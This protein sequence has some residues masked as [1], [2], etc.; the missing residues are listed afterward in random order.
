MH[1]NLKQQA[2]LTQQLLMTPRLQQAIKLLQLS[3]FELCQFI[4]RQVEENP[5]LDE[6]QPFIQPQNSLE[7]CQDLYS[8]DVTSDFFY[9]SGQ[10]SSKDFISSNVKKS[11]NSYYESKLYRKNTL[12]EYLLDQIACYQLTKEE[13]SVAILII[14]NINDEGYLDLNLSDFYKKEQLSFEIVDKVLNIIQKLEPMGVGARSLEECL[15]IQLKRLK[16]NN[17]LLQEIITKYWSYILTRRY[18]FIAKEL[19]VA[20]GQIIKSAAIISGL[21]P[22]PGRRFE[23]EATQYII[24]DVYVFKT[25]EEKWQ[26]ALNVEGIPQLKVNP[27]YMS[28]EQRLKKG[29]EKN[30]IRERLQAADWLVKSLAHRQHTIYKVVSCLLN[31]QR[32]FFENGISHLKPMTLQD[33]ASVVGMHESTISRVTSN[34]YIQTPRGILELKFFFNSQVNQECGGTK[35]RKAIKAIIKEILTKENSLKPH[36]DQK[37]V[38]ILDKKGLRIARRTVT[39][40]RNQLG[41]SSSNKRRS[42]YQD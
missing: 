28:L 19:N 3:R 24:P 23:F 25:E 1:L 21:E 29:K 15:F 42:F 7:V 26:I 2:K 34:K 32:A 35:S 13:Q 40:Y 30:Y 10:L 9:Y 38:D 14:G 6:V 11:A 41:F 39:K 20:V 12:A 18:E 5:A 33:V 36:S 16:I 37:L 22:I 17:S 4:S 27:Y 8:Y 31:K